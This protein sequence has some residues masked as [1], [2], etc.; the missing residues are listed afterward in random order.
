MLSL[1]PGNALGIRVVDVVGGPGD[2]LPATIINFYSSL[3]VPAYKRALA[4]LSDNLASFPRAVVKEGAATAEAAGHPLNRILKRRPNQFQNPFVF[5]RTLF[6]HAAHTGNGYALIERDPA[7][8][9]PVALQNALPELIV[10]VRIDAR[11]G[12]GWQQFYWNRAT[13][14]PIAGADVLH[15]QSLS[16]DGMAGMDPVAMHEGTFQRATTIERFQVQFL[17]KGTMVR[18]ALEIPGHLDNDQLEQV[19]AIVRKYRGADA[20]DDIMILT[21]GGKLNNAT[22]SPQQSQ[23][24]EQAV[25]TTK[26]I[27]QVTGV[28]PV[29]LYELTEEKYRNSVEQDGLNV[30]RFTFRP[31]IELAEDELTLKL[32]TEAEHDAGYTIKINPDALLR[33][34]TKTQTDTVVAQVNGGLRTRNEG[35]EVLGLPRDADPDSNRLKTLGDSSPKPVNA[36]PPTMAAAPAAAREEFTAGPHK[37]SSTQI[38]MPPDIAERVLAMAARIPEDHLADDGRETDPHVTVRY[39]LHTS[40]AADVQRVLAGEPPITFKLGKSSFFAATAERPS[41]VVKI[42]VESEDLT[43][44]NAKLRDELPNTQTHAG[45]EPHLTLAYV[46]PGMGK[47]YESLDDCEGIA[48]TLD[49]LTFSDREGRKTV[50]MLTGQR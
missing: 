8:F 17:R 49:R 38:D 50:I 42:D 6:F 32:L 23:L 21:D 34:D 20:E 22:T 44:L 16:W 36:P 10:P 9:R 29:F 37:F 12:R 41:D 30:V 1:N 3:S 43:R 45:Y 25:A 24:V 4:F 31:W 15:I 19:R 35:R 33:G 13:G 48:F 47:Q 5:W 7:T 26:Q 40:E 11:D 46:K 27:A 39:G 2:T 28:P 14:Q 18:G